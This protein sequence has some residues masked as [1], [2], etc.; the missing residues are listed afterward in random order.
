MG[1]R[2]GLWPQVLIFQTIRWPKAAA[3]AAR[4]TV[5]MSRLVTAWLT[6]CPDDL[7]SQLCTKNLFR[8]VSNLQG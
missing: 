2:G 1:S 4:R 8:C 5:F 7:A 3:T 6:R